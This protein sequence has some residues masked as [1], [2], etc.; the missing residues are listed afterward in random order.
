M[1]RRS[2]TLINILTDKLIF[3][4]GLGRSG[5]SFLC[6]IVSSLKKT[7]MYIMNSQAENIYYLNY[8]RMM[9]DDISNYFFKQIY[10]EKIYNLN[11]GRDLNRRKFDHSNIKKNKNYK[12][13]LSREKSFKEHD[14][15]IKDIRNSKK[16]LSYNV[17]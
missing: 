2:K 15:K 8:L 16:S 5:K 10:N 17:S 14:I 3:I 11:I 4:G 9:S 12:I 7:E 6:P 13:Y 1:Q